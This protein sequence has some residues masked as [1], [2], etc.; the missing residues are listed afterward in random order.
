MTTSSNISLCIV[1]TCLLFISIC[2]SH[3]AQSDVLILN[4]DR[5]SD[6]VDQYL[7]RYGNYPIDK[8]PDEFQHALNQHVTLQSRSI[9][10]VNVPLHDKDLTETS[11]QW[12][13]LSITNSSSITK[14]I[15]L[16]TSITQAKLLR[17]YTVREGELSLLLEQNIHSPYYTRPL[18]YNLLS[19]PISIGTNERLDVYMQYAGI[20]HYPMFNRISEKEVFD[21]REYLATLVHGVSLGVAFTLFL[22]FFLQFCLKPS[23][24]L[25]YYCLLTLSL[26]F[27]MAQMLGYNFKYLWPASG[28]FNVRL[29]SIAGSM[30]YVWYFLFFGAIFN[31]KQLNRLLYLLT[32]TAASLSTMFVVLGFFI[33][34]ST[35]VLWTSLFVIPMPVAVTLWA[36]FK[37]QPSSLLFLIGSILQCSFS[38]LF[39]L[40]CLGSI[41]L[42][43]WMFGLASMGQV[44]DLFLFAGAI[45]YQSK[46]IQQ[47]LNAHLLQ[48]VSDAEEMAVLESEKNQSLSKLQDY[49]LQLAAV[50]HD[51]IQPLASIK[52]ALSVVD[53]NE[54]K[55][56]KDKI[57]NTVLYAEKL[58]QSII[59]IA[60]SQY[61]EA[62]EIVPI[63]DIFDGLRQRY[64]ERINNKGLSFRCVNYGCNINCS[65]IV[66]NRILD[67]LVTNAMRYTSQGGILISARNRS[68]GVLIQVWDTGHG[69]AK[70]R[71]EEL[72][73]PFTQLN[74][75]DSINE[76]SGL[77]LHIVK[78]LTTN[79][80]FMFSVHSK[81][82]CGSCFSVL[83]PH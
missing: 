51:L 68:N 29:T 60:H 71:I 28:E 50:T 77:G 17:V 63:N 54:S 5:F 58:L 2:S 57:E 80:K 52:M 47:D 82:D 24:A 10:S 42:S 70:S 8:V 44:L 14:D 65:I 18:P 11:A 61:L 40:T 26:G 36:Y 3:W 21:S 75:E 73:R 25:A 59:H 9:P 78:A 4:D 46:I 55:S 32:L 41:D 56:A 38:Y 64:E 83:V 12:Y 69:I 74:A 19:V 37:R 33:E 43:R 15:R 16:S 53:D 79:A 1:Q 30:T 39:I 66:I 62:K 23:K 72:S 81:K 45:V 67:N 35:Y 20:A 13:K 34:L 48:K 31:L 7:E 49:S 6:S 27:F 76:G 22:F